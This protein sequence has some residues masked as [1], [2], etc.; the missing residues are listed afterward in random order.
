MMKSHFKTDILL[1]LL[2]GGDSMI[3]PQSQ[4]SSGKAQI[5]TSIQSWRETT[6]WFKK[7]KKIQ[8][9]VSVSRCKSWWDERHRCVSFLFFFFLDWT[10]AKERINSQTRKKKR[11]ANVEPNPFE[12]SP[13]GTH[14]ATVKPRIR[15]LPSN[16]WS[17]LYPGVVEAK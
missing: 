16:L 17:R 5:A 2:N 10:K 6:L 14:R 7:N 3:Y 15:R 4:K 12:M 8:S 1:L 13:L 9:W 11:S